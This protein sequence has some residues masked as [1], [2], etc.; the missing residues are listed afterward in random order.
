[1][2][3]EK[4]FDGA[5]IPKDE[6]ISLGWREVYCFAGYPVFSKE[7]KRILWDGKERRIIKT[8]SIR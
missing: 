7:D 1:M 8:Y 2:E 5:K 6:L 3:K 4:I